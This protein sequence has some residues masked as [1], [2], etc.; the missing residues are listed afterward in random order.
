[1]RRAPCPTF[2]C[3]GFHPLVSAFLS[4]NPKVPLPSS[5]P[6]TYS[7][8]Y[9]V[10]KF[11]GKK[12]RVSHRCRHP[13]TDMGNGFRRKTILSERHGLESEQRRRSAL[14]HSPF[15]ETGR[16][17]RHPVWRQEGALSYQMA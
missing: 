3:A 1:M 5:V 14:T 11:Y 6:I 2:A 9:D 10:S 17:H 7:A 15:T 16:D 12:A 4:S 13:S 8:R